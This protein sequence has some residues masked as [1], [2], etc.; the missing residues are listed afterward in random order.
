MTQTQTELRHTLHQHPELSNEETE[1][2]ER[3]CAFLADFAPDRI[4]TGLGGTGLAA[5]YEGGSPGP[6]LLFRSE[7]DALPIE[8]TGAFDH[9]S[10]TPGV[11]HKCGHD[12]HM[13]IVAGL[14]RHFH[15]RRPARGRVVL[16]F[17]PAEETG[18]GAARILDSADF[19]S[20]APDQ[21]YALHNLP[22]FPLGTVV[23]RDGVFAAGSTGM[24][25]RFL[26]T[27]SHAAEPEKGRS[28]ALAM[29][30]LITTL[31]QRD[32]GA[33]TFATIIH[34][35][36]GDRAFGV[37]PGFAET[38]ATLRSS[39]AELLAGLCKS[40]MTAVQELSTRHGLRS[41]VEWVEEFSV[42]RNSTDCVSRVRRAAEDLGVPVLVP[43]EP[44]RWSEDFG[45]F[46]DIYDGSLFGM[47]AGEEQP[48]L[49]R[50][51]Y[52]FPDALLERGTRLLL[53]VA[54]SEL[55]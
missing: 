11:S 4:L 22:G 50:P 27:T 21:V 47:G 26:G 41:E 42:T 15:E 3:I 35:R 51:E 37:T 34:A 14:A 40:A 23:L 54:R 43:I 28:P 39:D 18:E 19:R 36:L 30:E 52:D 5:I 6:C 46:T 33:D 7:L 25:A 20:L 8:E 44:F 48:A 2:A 31:G 9:R 38:F 32:V 13:T 12:G 1:T 45:R 24:V 16:L 17:Q 49:H 53:T 10:M 29:A 55:G